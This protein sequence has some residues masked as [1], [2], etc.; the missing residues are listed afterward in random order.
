MLNPYKTLRLQEKHTAIHRAVKTS[1]F[2]LFLETILGRSFFFKCILET[3][4][5]D[6]YPD[7]Y[8]FGPIG[9]GSVYVIICR[10]RSG[11]F[12]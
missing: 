1:S 3:S 5:V 9:S 7:P 12:P 2:F 8:I 11:S 4:V 10:D 6:F